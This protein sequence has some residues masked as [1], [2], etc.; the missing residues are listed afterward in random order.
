VENE[1]VVEEVEI[2]GPPA[3]AEAPEIA[4]P[5]AELIPEEHDPLLAEVKRT[6]R[7]VLRL[8]KELRREKKSATVE[9]EPA[10]APPAQAKV[11]PLTGLFMGLGLTKKRKQE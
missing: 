4:V 9:D 11:G 1:P 6:R 5:E 2:A 3:E 8:Q 10:V 7:A